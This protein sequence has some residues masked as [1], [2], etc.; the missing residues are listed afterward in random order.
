MIQLD[1]EWAYK[2]NGPIEIYSSSLVS[3]GGHIMCEWICLLIGSFQKWERA[4]MT[5]MFVMVRESQLQ[6]ALKFIRLFSSMVHC[7]DDEHNDDDDDD[8]DAH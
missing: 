7:A 8:H 4:N 6:I 1:R 3:L 5:K 2:D